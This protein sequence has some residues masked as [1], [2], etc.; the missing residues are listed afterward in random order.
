MKKPGV[1]YLSDITFRRGIVLFLLAVTILVGGTWMT[2]KLTA[3]H[4]IRQDARDNAVTWANSLAAHV[5]DLEQIASGEQPS[6]QSFAFF[7]AARS[8]GH[9]FRYVIYNR[10]GYSQLVSDANGVSPVDVSTHSSEASEAIESGSPVVKAQTGTSPDLPAYFAEAFVPV[11]VGGKIVAIVAAS[12]DETA[13]RTSFY[14]GSLALCSLTALAFAIPAIAWYRRTREKQRADRHIRF[15]AHH[16][17]LT[18]LAN[19]ARLIEKLDAAMALLPATGRWLAV[20]YLDIDN[21]KQVNDTLG[22][23]GG[24][25]LLSTI[26]KRLNAVVRQRGDVVARLGGDEFVVVQSGV[27]AK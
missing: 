26:G 22:H 8:V 20:H 19:R 27:R 7:S 16:D 2:I 3:D 15:L 6:T 12:V 14:T 13:Q 21:F 5:A 11:E 23:D 1:S 18:G 10:Q 17:S 25:F 24:D 9:V 4:F